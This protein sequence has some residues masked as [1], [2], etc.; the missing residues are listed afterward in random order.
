MDTR[1]KHGMKLSRNVAF[2]ET[3]KTVSLHR[4]DAVVVGRSQ[5]LSRYKVHY[6]NWDAT[7]WDEWVDADRI[8]WCPTF[9][10]FTSRSTAFSLRAAPVTERDILPGDAVEV[11]CPSTLGVSPWLET[12]VCK[13]EYTSAEHSC[14]SD[15]E[16]KHVAQSSGSSQRSTPR[17]KGFVCKQGIIAAPQ[18]MIP[19]NVRL[20]QKQPVQV[21]V[22]EACVSCSPKARA[23]SWGAP[24]GSAVASL[25][26]SAPQTPSPASRTSRWQR[27]KSSLRQVSF[28]RW[29]G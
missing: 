4:W 24:P 20:K 29:R 25:A 18:F 27:A 6:P 21:Q 14:W 13:V 15:S 19:G 10:R 3:K 26:Q 7:V 17:I 28:K 22:E 8:R 1:E 12:V 5:D 16:A 9:A 23:R 2:C 11:L